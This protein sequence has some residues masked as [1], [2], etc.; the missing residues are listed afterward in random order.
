M[1]EFGPECP[2]DYGSI[3]EFAVSD[4]ARFLTRYD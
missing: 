2:L 4:L 3:R 1:N